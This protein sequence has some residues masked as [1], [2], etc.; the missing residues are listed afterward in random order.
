MT[1]IIAVLLALC[2]LLYY[3]LMKEPFSAPKNFAIW[4]L[5]AVFLALYLQKLCFK[6]VHINPPSA[7]ISLF[8]SAVCVAGVF[9]APSPVLALRYS[10]EAM[11]YFVLAAGVIALVSEKKEKALLIAELAVLGSVPVCLFGAGQALH[12]D[13]F[14]ATTNLLLRAPFFSGT[15]FN[16][17]VSS[18]LGNANFLGGYF[19]M[20]IP[21]AAAL[22]IVSKDLKRNIY[23]GAITAVSL[24]LLI[25]T[26]TVNAWLAAGFALGVF[27]FFTVLSFREERKKALVLVVSLVLGTA[28]FVAAVNPQGALDKLSNIGR[29]NTL[30]EKGRA[31]MWQ[32]GYKMI[33][34]K[35]LTGFGP[36]S[37]RIFVP[38]YESRVLKTPG[39]EKHPFQ[40]TKDAH[41][42]FIQLWAETGVFGLLLFL[43]FSVVAIFAGLLKTINNEG[44]RGPLY[45][46]MF[47][48]LVGFLV[49]SFF[50]FPMRI[51]PIALLFWVYSGV[52]LSGFINRRVSLKG[53]MYSKP[54]FALGL[55]L[56][57][58]TLSAAVLIIHSNYYMGMGVIEYDR[59]NYQSSLEYCQKAISSGDL[60]DTTRDLRA[61][62]YTG[63]NYYAL[64][65]F[66][67]AKNEF[68]LELKLNPW[69]PDAHY[70][71][72]L[73]LEK[74]GENREAEEEFKKAF[75]LDPTFELAREKLLETGALKQ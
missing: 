38:L 36:G 15:I 7:V 16:E 14:N 37:Y 49:H 9:Y 47:S 33:K 18:T 6:K 65:N 13:F 12:F 68:D 61:R 48:A 31:V 63:N 22:F 30:A 55:V 69:H 72:G 40:M 39:Y 41:N 4:S 2:P 29:G 43:C 75:E 35:P 70:N 57:F 53:R 34:E 73:I 74:L 59:G 20:I 56:C 28:V 27:F 50:N 67:K 44:R 42:D 66:E 54:V 1:A 11:L 25:K 10:L 62:Y 51:A 17:R 60:V 71:R 32:A 5:S 8:F 19:L 26:E 3:P 46:G 24:F 58:I 23:Y 21:V 45:A 52:L 64:L